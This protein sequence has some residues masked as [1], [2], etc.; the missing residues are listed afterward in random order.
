MQRSRAVLALFLLTAG[1]VAFGQGTITFGSASYV[2]SASHWDATPDADLTG[3]GNGDQ[4]FEAGWWF[5]I[6][7]DTRE[8]FFPIPT[9]QNYTGGTARITWTDLGGRGLSVTKTHTILGIAGQGGVATT[10][11]VTNN[12]ASA[13]TL[14]LF[15]L[16]DLDVNGSAGGD[17]AALVQPFNTIRV[18]DAT[19]GYCEWRGEDAVGYLVLPFGAT[20]VSAQL[21]DAAVT[22]FANTGLPF[23]PGDFTGGLQW[24]LYLSP[25]ASE[26]VQVYLNCNESLVPVSLQRF[27]VD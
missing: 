11:S 1:P 8:T 21:R 20:D 26:T 9:T 16:I 15:Q 3:V 7:G 4:L 24:T 22:N 6:Q 25:G 18:T 12:G 23:G 2:L 14:H 17:S 13:V 10:L 19:A 5:R 27:E